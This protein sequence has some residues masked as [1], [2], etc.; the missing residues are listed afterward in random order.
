MKIIYRINLKKLNV[1]IV[2]Q[3]F[4]SL[5]ASLKMNFHSILDSNIEIKIV[6]L[7]LF[8][9]KF[10]FN[11]CC[12]LAGPPRVKSRGRSRHHLNNSCI[13]IITVGSSMCVLSLSLRYSRRPGFSGDTVRFIKRESERVDRH[14]LLLPLL[15]PF[16]PS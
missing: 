6:C 1:C 3:I 11:R 16:L 8:L 7:D 2:S 5:Q 15:L 10:R 12:P 9:I 14:L 13:T 4:N